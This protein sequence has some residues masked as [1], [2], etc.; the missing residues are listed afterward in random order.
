MPR[1]GHQVAQPV[2]RPQRPLR[3]GRHLHQVDIEVQQA[4][5][6]PRGWRV[7]EQRLE[8]L[9]RLLRTGVLRHAAGGQVPHLPRR[10][11]HDGFDEHAGDLEVAVEGL[12]EL[13]HLARERLVPVGL[14]LDGVALRVAQG[15]RLDQRLLDRRG[16]LGE[17]L[18]GLHGVVGR[19]QRR[20]LARRIV[21]V[22]GQVV[23]GAGGVGDAPLRH[24]APGIV[25]ERLAEALDGLGVVEAEGPVQAAVEPDLRFGGFGGDGAGVGAEI[26]VVHGLSPKLCRRASDSSRRDGSDQQ[27]I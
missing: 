19:G 15:Q 18:R 8:H 24:G 13:A 26:V 14:V 17:R 23:V 10:L 1:I 11:V 20:R 21:E 22:P 25:L 6:V 12:V 27:K 4:G 2:A 3:E 7:G 16:A 9:H 5:M